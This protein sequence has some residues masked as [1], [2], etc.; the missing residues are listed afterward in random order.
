[1]I[2]QIKTQFY[3]ILTEDLRYKVTDNPYG[4]EQKSFPYILLTLQNAYRDKRKNSYLYTIKMK[5]DIFSDY[6]GEKEI[7]DM[8]QA[9]YEKSDKLLENDFITYVRESS[10]RIMDDKS[11]GVMRKHGIITYTI[12]CAGGIE[13]NGDDLQTNE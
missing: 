7:Y 12:Y 8:E 11:T 9:I 10:F 13:E 2:S 6:N 1:M 5:I 4:E 3:K